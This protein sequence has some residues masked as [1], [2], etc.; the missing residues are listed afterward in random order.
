[1]SSIDH[2]ALLNGYHCVQCGAKKNLTRDH[3]WPKSKGGC[4]CVGN[5]QIL[6]YDC[7]QK[8]GDDIDE[9]GH[10]WR[11]CPGRK[12]RSLKERWKKAREAEDIEKAKEI[13]AEFEKVRK[14]LAGNSFWQETAL[15]AH[16]MIGTIRKWTTDEQHR[17][18]NRKKDGVKPL[19]Y[20][21]KTER[22][23]MDKLEEVRETIRALKAQQD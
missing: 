16:S 1:M 11:D 20:W 19:E 9:R 12:Y 23:L 18:N 8:K 13:L 17:V 21:E 3:I 15:K 7:N 6:C 14:I 2:I 10:R 22:I 4:G 5:I